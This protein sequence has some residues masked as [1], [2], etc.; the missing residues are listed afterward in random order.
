MDNFIPFLLLL[1]QERNVGKK[2]AQTNENPVRDEILNH[3]LTGKK[4]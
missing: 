4:V 3:L 2:V 1:R